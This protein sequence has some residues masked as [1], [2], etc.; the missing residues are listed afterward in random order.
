MV[1]KK[2]F[3]VKN[4]LVVLL[5]ILQGIIY[6]F[7]S[8]KLK[9]RSVLMRIILMTIAVS[10]I[11]S[12]IAACNV[13]CMQKKYEVADL[14]DKSIKCE[15]G[16]SCIFIAPQT[17]SAQTDCLGQISCGVSINSKVGSDIFIEEVKKIT[18]KM[19]EQCGD[20][21]CDESSCING[22]TPYCDVD[23][24]RCKFSYCFRF[25]LSLSGLLR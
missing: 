1:Y 11:L 18:L 22:V 20:S 24:G 8:R 15:E 3:H 9:K 14:V 10:V 17:I 6:P 19:R 5:L 16:D 21:Y 2:N 12:T 4:I 25:S 13:E 7:I 23:A